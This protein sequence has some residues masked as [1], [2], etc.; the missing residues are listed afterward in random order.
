[1][2]EKYLKICPKCGSIN[3]KI[4]PAGMDIKMTVKDYCEDCQ[5]IGNFPEVKESEIENFRKKL[6]K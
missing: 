5:N 6:R 1:M 2:K 3:I 4:P